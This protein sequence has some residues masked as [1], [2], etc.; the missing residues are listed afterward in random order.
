ME[1]QQALNTLSDFYKTGSSSKEESHKRIAYFK[2]VIEHKGGHKAFHY[3][4]KSIGT[5]EDLQ[6]MFRLVWYGT[7][8]VLSAEVND[9]RGPVDF[10]ASM[11]VHDKTLIEM[12]LARSKQLKRNLE[13]QLPI[14]QKASDANHG[15][16]VIIFFTHKEERLATKTLAELSLT[17]DPDIV[18]I[19]ARADNKPSGSK[20]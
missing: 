5:E 20:A 15:I 19:D 18:L 6:R 7:P 9:G 2:D 16:K 10:M 17:N 12:K 8:A 13:K 14:Y 11:S 4:G 3:K 1:L